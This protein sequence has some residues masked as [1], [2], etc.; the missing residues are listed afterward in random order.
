MGEIVVVEGRRNRKKKHGKRRNRNRS[1]RNKQQL[2]TIADEGGTGKRS[3]ML[4][5]VAHTPELQCATVQ[6]RH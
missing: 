4:V 5:F 2:W 6:T 1:D 3:G